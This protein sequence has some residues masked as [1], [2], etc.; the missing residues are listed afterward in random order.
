MFSAAEDEQDF[1]DLRN[2]ISYLVAFFANDHL[3]APRRRAREVL[4]AL[5]LRIPACSDKLLFLEWQNLTVGRLCLTQNLMQ[6]QLGWSPA[7]LLLGRLMTLL[8]STPRA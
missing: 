8:R 2:K 3:T 1:P 5:L 4:L 7:R 6:F